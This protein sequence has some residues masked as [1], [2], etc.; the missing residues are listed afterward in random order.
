MSGASGNTLIYAPPGS[1][2]ASLLVPFVSGIHVEAVFSWSD[3]SHKLVV[4]WPRGAPQP[5]MK[6]VF[7]GAKSAFY[8]NR[9]DGSCTQLGAA[10]QL[11]D[12][13]GGVCLCAGR[14]DCTRG[15][16]E[17]VCPMNYSYTDFDT[18]CHPPCDGHCSCME[19]IG[20]M[21]GRLPPL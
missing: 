1:G 15:I 7:E 18:M 3:K 8:D 10:C 17:N 12:G 21:E 19:G 11:G 4:D 14:D 9:N 6:G 5:A 2:I 20:C 16:C 13:R